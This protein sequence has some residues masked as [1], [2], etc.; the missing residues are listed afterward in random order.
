MFKLA[1]IYRGKTTGG[2]KRVIESLLY[3]FDKERNS[4]WVL[5]TDKKECVGRYK[6]IQVKYLPNIG[7]LVGYFF[8]DYFQSFIYLLLNNFDSV[9]Y[10][11]GSIP[12]NHLLL[13]LKKIIT[14][15]DLAYFE[16]QLNAYP[17]IDTFFMQKQ[18]RFSG[19]FA[20][21]IIAISQFTKEDIIKRFATRP[22]KVEVVY[23]A[24]DKHFKKIKDKSLIAYYLKKYNIKRP[25]LFYSG[26]ISPRK[27]LLRVLKAFNQIKD[28]MKHDLVITGDSIWGE[29]EIQK[30]INGNQL[31]QRVKILGYVPEEDLIALYSAA[32]LFIYLSLYE[33]FGLPILEAQAC[34]CPVLTSDITSCPEVAGD[35]A[36][37]VD[38]YSVEEIKD[39]IEQILMNDEYRQALIKKGNKNVKKFSWA[40]TAHKIIKAIN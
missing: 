38:P 9:F 18:L 40:A 25:F 1:F 34:G 15:Y 7:G 6:N 29:N 5:I 22:H 28:E 31:R 8:W 3:E 21:K 12:V 19:K 11:K 14:I 36:H 10:S 27:N 4:P 23:L 13:R 37:L 26:S 35:G 32:D 33:G 17:L 39:G 2:T 24:V 20:D 16:K 30:Y